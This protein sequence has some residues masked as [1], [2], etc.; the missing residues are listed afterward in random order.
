MMTFR[1]HKVRYLRFYENR[2]KHIVLKKMKC[3]ALSE[4]H[5]Q[6]AKKNTKKCFLAELINADQIFFQQ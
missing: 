6:A 2:L 3:V 1:K 4:R 5:L